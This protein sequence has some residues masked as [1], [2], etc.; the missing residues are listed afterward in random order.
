MLKF[1]FFT[2]A[3]MFSFR[4]LRALFCLPWAQ[5]LTALRQPPKN[6]PRVSVVLAA[7]DEEARI[8]Q[9]LRYILA[10]QH[11]DL[12]VIPVSDRAIDRTDCILKQLAA[13]DFR[14]R[15]Q[16]VDVLPERWLGKC[17]ACHVGALS[18][19]GDW[20]LFTDADCWLKPDV[21]ARAIAVT[22]R[23]NVDHV[24]LTPGVAPQTVPAE[25]WHIGFLVSLAHWFARVNQDK[26]NGHL[27]VGAF[28]LMRRSLYKEFGGYEALRLCVVDDIKLGQL[29]R[30]A[31]GRT[32][33][34]IGGDDVECHWGVTVGSMIK[35]ME[36][37][38]FAALDYRTMQGIFFGVVLN[39]LWAACIIGP[40]FR[41]IYGFWAAGSLLLSAIPAAIACK[42]LRWPLRGAAFT[43][44]VFPALYYAVLNSTTVTL[45]QRG[46]R[47]RDTFYPLEMLRAGNVR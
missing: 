22:E 46:I 20:L 19:T 2:A 27:G 35:I 38:F 33:A 34:F 42:R 29:V 40:F 4:S 47:W 11:I 23:E 10:Q 26:P 43:P 15:P 28:N 18:A 14:V 6:R 37:N 25:A 39:I 13:E 45:R 3:L 30:R 24:T 7:R 41:S 9:T 36:K 1:L 8:E 31:G 12:E 16:R 17:H 5:R 44:F 21:I 32:R